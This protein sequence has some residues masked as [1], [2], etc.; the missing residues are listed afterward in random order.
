MKSP[1]E[2]LSREE[3]DEL[4][5]TPV[6]ISILIAGEDNTFTK[7]EIKNAVILV[8]QRKDT[9]NGFLKD[10]YSNAAV[11]F[12]VN[13]RGYITLLPGS[14][15]QRTAYLVKRLT[16]VNEL[17]EKMNMEHAQQLYS[18]F[19]EFASGVAKYSG[20]LFGLLSVT[21]ADSKFID[22]KM[23]RNPSGSTN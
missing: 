5:L 3:L 8:N 14:A 21:F 17:L 13:M 7:K 2:K 6:W 18:S 11:K 19:R 16:K 12:E 23:I 1:F 4:Y 10:F 20:G 9:G 22:L 15:D